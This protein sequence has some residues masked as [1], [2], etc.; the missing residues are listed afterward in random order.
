MHLTS[1]ITLR[2]PQAEVWRLLS[3]PT[4]SPRWDRSIGAIQILSP[5]PFGLG[6]TVQTTAPGGMVQR[7]RITEWSPPTGFAFELMASPWFKTA[8]LAFTLSPE[9]SGT[10]VV[11]DIDVAFRFP[12]SVLYPVLALVSDRALGADLEQLR[13]WL[14]EGVDLTE[15]RA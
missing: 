9:G 6:S 4:T 14:D 7:F 15:G 5:D 8:R 10:R 2:R 11:H 12:W 13:L 1:S 3:D